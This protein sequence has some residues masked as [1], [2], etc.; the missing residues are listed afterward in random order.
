MPG[1]NTDSSAVLV[2]CAVVV[3]R[4]KLDAFPKAYTGPDTVALILNSVSLTISL[5]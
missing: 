4:F 2:T 3:T 5:M 1:Y